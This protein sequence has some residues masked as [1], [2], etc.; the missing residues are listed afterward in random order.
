MT[1]LVIASAARGNTGGPSTSTKHDS[2]AP[3]SS[4]TMAAARTAMPSARIAAHDAFEGEQRSLPE[5]GDDEEGDRPRDG[6]PEPGEPE[7]LEEAAERAQD[8]GDPTVEIDVELGPQGHRQ[9][10]DE[11]DRR[12]QH[13]DRPPRPGV[14]RRRG[15]EL[16]IHWVPRPRHT[17]P[18]Q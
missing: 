10:Q 7:H 5:R 9:R 17:P 18:A 12:P 11:V 14:G 3:A 8:L 15:V 1:A 13:V 4:V 6:T 2:T 16:C